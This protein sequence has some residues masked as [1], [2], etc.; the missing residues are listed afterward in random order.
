MNVKYFRAI[1][2]ICITTL[3]HNINGMSY[4]CSTRQC[5]VNNLNNTGKGSSE[6][7]QHRWRWPMWNRH[8]V[9]HMVITLLDRVLISIYQLYQYEMDMRWS[10]HVTLTARRLWHVLGVNVKSRHVKS[11]YPQTPDGEPKL[12][13]CWPTVCDAEPTINQHWLAALYLLWCCFIA[14]QL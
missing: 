11:E 1:N 14:W 3:R 4:P 9:L 7:N 6:L 13:Y 12:G 2:R 10:R 8:P 5:L